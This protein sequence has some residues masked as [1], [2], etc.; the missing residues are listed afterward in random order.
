MT[1]K[2]F[3]AIT[4]LVTFVPETEVVQVVCL[5]TN[6]DVQP[7]TVKWVYTSICILLA[8]T[9]SPLCVAPSLVIKKSEYVFIRNR[10]LDR[11]EG[12]IE[13]DID[14]QQNNMPIKETESNIKVDCNDSIKLFIFTYYPNHFMKQ[15]Q[16]YVDH[17]YVL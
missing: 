16:S 13:N 9:I 11:T 7:H 1:R 10:E 5:T 4:H 17:N 2:V 6:S 3:Y 12:K 15:I 8:C 14:E